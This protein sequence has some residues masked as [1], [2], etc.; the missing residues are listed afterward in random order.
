MGQITDSQSARLIL[1]LRWVARVWGVCLLLIWGAFFVEHLAWFA[2]ARHLPPSVFLIQALHLTLLLGF[3]LAWRYE[4]LGGVI[5]L[6]AST[7]FF[8]FVAGPNFLTFTIV[9][10][11]PAWIWILCGL[12]STRANKRAN[13]SINLSP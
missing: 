12:W 4:I 11:I 2:D 1:L 9:T 5:V 6:A 10:T 3:I 13:A 8:A 7:A